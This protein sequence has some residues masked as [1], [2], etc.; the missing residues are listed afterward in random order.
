M[1]AAR[2]RLHPGQVGWLI[3]ALVLVTLPHVERLPWW[4]T[5]LAATLLAWRVYI[6]GHALHM[7]PKWLLFF[8]ASGTEIGRAHV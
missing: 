2:E 1:N 7:P 4:I 6:T 8:V 3:A 5:T